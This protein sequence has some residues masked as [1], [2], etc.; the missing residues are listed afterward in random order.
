M[1]KYVLAYHGG[2][3]MP[4][5]E[6]EQ[7]AIMEAWGAWFVGMGEA[8]VDGGNPIGQTKTITSDGA[9]SDGGGANPIT[10]YSLISAADMDAALAL[11]GTCPTLA[12]GGNVEVAEAIDM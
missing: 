2:S 7:A 5:S 3:A 6:A 1:P 4:D 8:V 12:A 9:A 11:A 10:G